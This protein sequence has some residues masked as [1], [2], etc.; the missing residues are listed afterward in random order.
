MWVGF[1]G[2]QRAVGDHRDRQRP[3]NFLETDGAASELEA[4]KAAVLSTT[5][6]ITMVTDNA[7]IVR[8]I[9]KGPHAKHDTNAHAWTVFWE[10]VGGIVA[11]RPSR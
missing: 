8:G 4:V 7:A 2:P 10:C 6:A 9:C 1:C 5:G 3:F 11:P